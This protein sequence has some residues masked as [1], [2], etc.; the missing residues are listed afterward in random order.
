MTRKL[1][2][3]ILT[4]ALAWLA[5]LTAPAKDM[6]HPEKGVPAYTF[7]LPD[8]WS[9]QLAEADNLIMANANRSTVLV[10]FVGAS[11]EPLDVIAKEA[12]AVAKATASERKEP[13][14]ISGCEGFTWFTTIKNDAG[15]TLN[16]ETT[17][18]RIGS[19]H[20]ASASL[21]LAPGVTPA[22]ETAARLVRNGLKL[23]KQ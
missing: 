13:A 6:R 4:L 1:L 8:D 17:I 11:T 5:P 3:V 15:L 21:I 18:V 9:A 20:V 2:L 10:V 23:V 19:E 22:D 12:F 16:L 14:E 7:V